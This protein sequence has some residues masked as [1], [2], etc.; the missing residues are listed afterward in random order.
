P[1]G[2]LTGRGVAV[3]AR[4][5]PAPGQT[6]L[7]LSRRDDGGLVLEVP[8]PETG[9]GSHSVARQQLAAALGIPPAAVEVRQAPTQSLSYDPGV[10]ASRI[11]VGISS[12]IAQLAR[13]WEDSGDSSVTVET[14][15]GEAPALAYCAQQA[16]VAVDPETGKVEVLRLVSAVD[17]ADI[18]RPASHRLQIEGGALMGWGFACLEDLLEEDGQTWAANLSEFKLPTAADSPDL[19]TVL[20]TGGR[21]VGPA[22]VKA[23]GELS[24]VAVAAAVANAVADATGVQIRDLPVTAERVYWTLR[25]RRHS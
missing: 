16:T 22:N 19:R 18:V 20:V 2:R 1:P 9:T 15:P 12:A 13:R 7:R 11:T 23:V 8:F 6:S 25:E 24:N 14:Q 17:V 21:G 10:G 3:Y 5:T 4:P